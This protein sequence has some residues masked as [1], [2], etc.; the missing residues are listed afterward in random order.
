[1]SFFKYIKLNFLSLLLLSHSSPP[2]MALS[3]VDIGFK[4]S[5]YGI[6][7]KSKKDGKNK[8]KFL[9]QFS[10]MDGLTTGGKE[11]AINECWFSESDLRAQIEALEDE[12]LQQDF[13]TALFGS[14]M[15]KKTL[16]EG[17]D[18]LT[19]MLNKIKDSPEEC[20]PRTLNDLIEEM[21]K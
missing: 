11:A 13:L 20:R 17:F 6:K 12:A 14:I 1:M 15:S 19:A 3:P 10:L 18:A 7:I 21:K 2:S 5:D 4:G 16:Q 9:Y 8:N